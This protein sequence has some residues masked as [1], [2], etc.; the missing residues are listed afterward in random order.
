MKKILPVLL[1]SALSCSLFAG[2]EDAIKSKLNKMMPELAIDKI[3][4]TP[5][6]SLYLVQSGAQ[7]LY[8]TADANTLIQ[9]DM[10]DI[11]NSDKAVNLSD[12]VRQLGTKE[13]LS[14]VDP[15]TMIIYQAKPEKTSI[16]V[17][18]DIDCGYCRALHKEV[19]EL[20]AAGVTVRYLA[21][22]R[23]P[24]GTPSYNKA[25]YVWCAKDRNA[26]LTEAKSGKEPAVASCNNP[27]D[28]HHEIAK[29]IGV[30]VTPV[31][32]LKNGQMIPG[33][34][35]AKELIKLAME[36]N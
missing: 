7:V 23:S 18:T 22:P 20:N 28:Q 14:K 32:I 8:V 27:V 21:F 31:I 34:V 30:N 2:P 6:P 36:N 4:S 13:I 11:H 24:K 10:Y 26:A 3:Q 35:P 5:I 19:K 29:A 33:Y 17:F 15:A 1:L 9:G 12:N 25:V 16:T